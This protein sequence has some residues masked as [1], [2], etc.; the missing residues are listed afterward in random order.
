MVCICRLAGSP[1]QFSGVPGKD[2][3]SFTGS[4]TRADDEVDNN[5]GSAGFGFYA[6]ANNGNN[7]TAYNFDGTLA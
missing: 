2:Y 5:A 3:D 1:V 6:S 4:T 7:T